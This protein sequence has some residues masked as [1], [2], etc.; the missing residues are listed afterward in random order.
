MAKV[1]SMIYPWKR[2]PIKDDWC[3]IL[4]ISISA[5][6]VDTLSF[7]KFGHRI[8]GED[9]VVFCTIPLTH[10]QHLLQD[11]PVGGQEN[12]IICIPQGTIP[13]ATYVASKLECSK[14]S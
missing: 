4:D 14:F 2:F 3:R 11:L 7:G 5:T 13:P 10:H 6:E 12:Q 8:S 9:K 1:D